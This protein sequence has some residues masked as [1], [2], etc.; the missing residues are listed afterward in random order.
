MIAQTTYTQQARTDFLAKADDRLVAAAAAGKHVVVTHEVP[1]PEA[2]RVVKIPDAC[3]AFAV[4]SRE[5]F[6]LFGE[7]GLQLVRPPRTATP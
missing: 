1:A 6:R 2:K 5:P 4:E 3:A 7:L